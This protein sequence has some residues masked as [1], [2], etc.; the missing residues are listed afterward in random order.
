MDNC[1]GGSIAP[2]T[3]E[4]GA[5]VR[6]ASACDGFTN[7]NSSDC[8]R[9]GVNSDAEESGGGGMKVGALES[10]TGPGA[11]PAACSSALAKACRLAKRRCGSLARAISITCSTSG[12][13]VGTLSCKDGREAN[14]CWVA[15]SVNDP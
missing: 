1:V 11:F 15:I 2:G 14:M 5:E 7:V 8:D 9:T 10:N 4:I 6:V 3:A 12:V 13:I